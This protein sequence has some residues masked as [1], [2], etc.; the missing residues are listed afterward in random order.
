[1]VQIFRIMSIARDGK[2]RK[3]NQPRAGEN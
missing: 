1:M 2:R 3:P